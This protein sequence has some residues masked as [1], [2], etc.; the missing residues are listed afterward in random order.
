MNFTQSATSRFGLIIIG[1]ELLFGSRNDQHLAHFRSLLRAH[2]KQLIRSWILPDEELSL[3]RHLSF[4]MA[5]QH[6]VFVCGGIGA[7]PDDLTRSCAAQASGVTL[8]R[9]SEAKHL[10]EDQF[11]E[12]A[13]PTR[14]KM[15][16]LPMGC[17]LIPNPHNQIPG[18]SIN[19]H[20]FLPGFPEMAWPMAEWVLK[21]YYSGAKC[22]FQEKSLLVLNTPESSL[23]P[24]M[25]DMNLHLSDLKLFSLPK[26]GSQG[27]I[28]LGLRGSGD[29][30]SA[31]KLLQKSLAEYEIPFQMIE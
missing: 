1:D 23:V 11:G 27:T 28:E 7:T 15:A 8:E 10:I 17:D 9:H 3:T 24:L 14:I 4:S 29:I 30:D 13:Y 25:D 31:F 6:P 5:A 20:Y 22:K 19:R 26:F 18:F 12:A 16:D 21:H 2:G